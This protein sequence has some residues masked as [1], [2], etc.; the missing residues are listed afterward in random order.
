M[1]RITGAL[2]VLLFVAVD[3]ISKYLV[4]TGLPLQE[5]VQLLPVLS[6]FRTY[7]TGIAFSF[8][9]GLDDT[10]LV[11]L[12][13]AISGVIL[14]LWWRSEPRQIWA[15]LGYA[16]VLGGAIGNLIDR[17]RDPGNLGTIIRTVDAV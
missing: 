13:L 4:E 12:T 15:R 1:N 5:P 10:L 11:L 7:N 2:L 16:F 6:L 3:Q 8:L 9:S 14:Y 17:V